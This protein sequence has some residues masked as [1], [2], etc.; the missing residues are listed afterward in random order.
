MLILVGKR[1]YLPTTQIYKQSP[2][3]T[4]DLMVVNLLVILMQSL[5]FDI[6]PLRCHGGGPILFAITRSCPIFCQEDSRE[7]RDDFWGDF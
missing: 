2:V 5:P 7:S 1:H 3:L 4:I 6:F